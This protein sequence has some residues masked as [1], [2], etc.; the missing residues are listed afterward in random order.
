MLNRGG[1][2][3][4]DEKGPPSDAEREVERSMDERED[5]LGANHHTKGY[6][7]G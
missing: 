2:R 1:M 6:E 5:L 4:G 3:D 7:T